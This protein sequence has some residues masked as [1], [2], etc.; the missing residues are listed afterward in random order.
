MRKEN[1]FILLGSLFGLILVFI[2]PPFQSPD[3]QAHLYRAWEIGEGKLISD[4]KCQ[5]YLPSNLAKFAEISSIYGAAGS[6]PRLW[7]NFQKTDKLKVDEEMILFFGSSCPYPLTAFL[8]YSAS[9]LLGEASNLSLVKIFYLG[10]ISGLLLYLLLVYS[11]IKITPC[12]KNVFLL[13]GL[14]PMAIFQAASWNPDGAV[15]GF[16]FLFTACVLHLAFSPKV[17]LVGAAQFGR[18][19]VLSVLLTVSKIA[20]FPLIFLYFLIPGKRFSSPRKRFSLFAAIFLLNS[21]LMAVWLFYNRNLEVFIFASKEQTR[22]QLSFVVHNVFTY[23]YVAFQTTLIIYP[24]EYFSQFYGVLGWLDNPLPFL[25]AVI[26][27][28][29]L[30][31]LAFRETPVLKKLGMLGI[32]SKWVNLA[33]F[34]G[35]FLL[36]YLSMA[37]ILYLVWTPKEIVGGDRIL[38]TQG[39]YF[40]PFA[41]LI[42]FSLPFIKEVFRRKSAF[43]VL[44]VLLLSLGVCAYSVYARYH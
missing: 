31:Y 40:L 16:S 32:K 12:F 34:L 29:F 7:E 13:L 43:V 11:A 3:E 44:A 1:I 28:F 25:L 6:K 21:F 41:P 39:R 19:L 26:Y 30:G 2:N 24:Y 23:L 9:V 27:I 18:L 5:H 42:F 37:S 22:S 10:R 36:T 14:I 38:G 15:V 4:Q 33:V 20:Y 8:P 17:S 35:V